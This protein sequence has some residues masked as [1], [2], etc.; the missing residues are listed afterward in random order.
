MTSLVSEPPWARRR[1]WDE[2]R[3]GVRY[4]G[5]TVADA[6]AFVRRP[7]SKVVAAIAVIGPSLSMHNARHGKIVPHDVGTRD[8]AGD[9]VGDRAWPWCWGDVVA[10]AV[11]DTRAPGR[12]TTVAFEHD[13]DSDAQCSAGMLSY[14]A[15]LAPLSYGAFLAP[16]YDAILRRGLIEHTGALFGL[17]LSE[18]H[19]RSG[20]ARVLG[21][22]V[23]G[24]PAIPMGPALAEEAL[25]AV[26][27][28]LDVVRGAEREAFVEALAKKLPR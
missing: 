3:A 21:P 19:V 7:E 20:F 17:R 12:V 5:I 4:V 26:D 15:F 9:R 22:E 11:E 25:R 14:S 28:A 1:A 27:R 16:G 13:S 23:M 18:D 6:E 10:V 24:R 8:D 2:M